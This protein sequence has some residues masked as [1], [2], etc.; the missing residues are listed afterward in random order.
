MN[1]F[2]HIVYPFIIIFVSFLSGLVLMPFV[3]RFARAK[4]L[5]VRPNKRTSHI[6]EVP[7]VGGL[8]IFIVLMTFFVISLIFKQ[9]NLFFVI[10]FCIIFIIGFID[11]R[12]ELSAIWKLFG[13]T[14]GAFFLIKFADIRILSL[15]GM[16]GIYE[17]PLWGSYLISFAVF[18]LIVNALNLIDGVDGLASGLGIVYSAFFGV[19]FYSWG[20]VY[21]SLICFVAIGA[22]L[23]FFLYNVFG[24]SRRKIFMGDSGSLPLGYLI[25]F[26]VFSVHLNNIEFTY[27]LAT[28]F[29]VLFMPLFDMLRVAF[30][31]LV[32]HNNIFHPDKNHIHHLLL[33]LGL[34]HKKVS[35]ILIF[36]SLIFVL[37]ALLM[38]HKHYLTQ[39]LFTILT[40]ITLSYLLWLLV[41]KKHFNSK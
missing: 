31:R 36:V 34:S 39:I 2:L 9:I 5:V 40:G 20:N 21:I 7:N 37:I 33:K 25:T 23:V 15:G 1:P 3:I 41:E 13:E 6:G 38:M 30:T 11:D 18:I 14:F 35:M 24:G 27:P 19:W 29:I 10:G 26:F 8:N 4:N 16:F 17:L 12:L 28:S 22:L 32:N